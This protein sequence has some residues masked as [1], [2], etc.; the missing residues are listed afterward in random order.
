MMQKIVNDQG[1]KARQR[2]DTEDRTICY[3]DWLRTVK[4]GG[5]FLD[6]DMIKFKKTPEGI[7]PCCITELTRSDSETPVNDG[8]LFAIIQRYFYRDRQGQTIQMVADKLQIPAYLVLFGENMNWLK[9]YSF[10]AKIWK[11]FTPEAW[12]EHLKTL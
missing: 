5:F 1:Q 3:K 2:A 7:V 4:C 6:L 10:Q 12:A 8:Y 11:D 9:V